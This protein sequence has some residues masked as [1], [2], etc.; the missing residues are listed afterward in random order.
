VL[1]PRYEE[2]I[3]KHKINLLQVGQKP[4]VLL[5]RCMESAMTHR[6]II[7]TVNLGAHLLGISPLLDYR[8]NWSGL[9]SPCCDTHQC[10]SGRAGLYNQV[11]PQQISH[12]HKEPPYLLIGT[13]SRHQDE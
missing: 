12:H 4:C 2:Q 8:C 7:E 1:R 6:M 3:A 9:H 5:I 11:R 13:Y 10:D